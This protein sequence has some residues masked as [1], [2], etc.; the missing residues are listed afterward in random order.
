MI[1]DHMVVLVV[2]VVLVVAVVRS[3][4]APA[5]QDQIMVEQ[6]LQDKVM[7]EEWVLDLALLVQLAA[8]AVV[9]PV[10]LDYGDQPPALV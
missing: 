4:L 8:A 3:T 9:V 2:L 5:L 10:E 6:G 7:M 1:Q